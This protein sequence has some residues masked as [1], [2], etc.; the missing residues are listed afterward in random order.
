MKKFKELFEKQDYELYHKSYTSAVQEAERYANSQGFELD[1]E[2]MADKIGL[3]PK[4]P[5]EG[6]TNKFS[7]DLYKNGEPIKGKRKFHFQVYNRGNDV[8]NN[9]ELNLYIS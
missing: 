7:L 6:K 2:E 5:S 8:G 3:G 9:F 4:K 1:P